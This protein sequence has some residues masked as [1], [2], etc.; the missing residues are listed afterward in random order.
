MGSKFSPWQRACAE[1]RE[2]CCQYYCYCYHGDQ[3]LV[4]YVLERRQVFDR[5][6]TTHFPAES[7]G[8]CPHYYV[9]VYQLSPL[10]GGVEECGRP[11]WLH[12]DLVCDSREGSLWAVTLVLCLLVVEV[13]GHL[14]PVEVEGHL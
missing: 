2:R 14:L 5:V 7:A 10:L 8:G 4:A 3:T 1:R 11:K 6:Q 9:S 13:E 12:F